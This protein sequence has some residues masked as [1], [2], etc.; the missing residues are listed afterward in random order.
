[1]KSFWIWAD[2]SLRINSSPAGKWCT[3]AD[4]IPRKASGSLDTFSG[5]GQMD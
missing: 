2:I 1:M 4:P 3:K 5:F